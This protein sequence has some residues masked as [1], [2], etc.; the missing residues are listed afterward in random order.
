MKSVL[1]K[2]TPLAAARRTLLCV[3]AYMQQLNK[4]HEL[5]VSRMHNV[6]NSANTRQNALRSP[7]SLGGPVRNFTP[8]PV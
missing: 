8:T 3:T 7:N 4:R 2:P 1:E 6:Q 5:K